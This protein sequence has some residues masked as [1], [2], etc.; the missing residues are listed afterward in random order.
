MSATTTTTVTVAM[1]GIGGTRNALAGIAVGD[2]TVEHV[3]QA[4]EDIAAGTGDTAGIARDA[5]RLL[6]EG[7]TYAALEW[8]PRVALGEL[9]VAAVVR[10][11]QLA[12]PVSELLHAV[13][14]AN[15]AAHRTRT[16]YYPGAE[17]PRG[18]EALPTEGWGSL[19]VA[20]WA[21]RGIAD[22]PACAALVDMQRLSALALRAASHENRYV[23]QV[24]FAILA[25]VCRRCCSQS[26]SSSLSALI[27]AN[28]HVAI[29]KA[30]SDSWAQVRFAAAQAA[31]AL[32]DMCPAE[33]SFLPAMLPA[34]FV[35][36]HDAAEGVR[37]QAQV[38]WRLAVNLSGKQL[39][40]AHVEPVTALLAEMCTSGSHELR[41]AA[42]TA[43]GELAAAVSQ[44]AVK[45]HAP[46]ILRVILVGLRDP[47]WAVKL[48]ACNAYHDFAG[49]FQAIAR[50]KESGA[51]DLLLRLGEDETACVREASAAALGAW[52]RAYGLDERALVARP[53]LLARTRHLLEMIRDEPIPEGSTK[54]SVCGDALRKAHFNDPAVHVSQTALG[55]CSLEPAHSDHGHA[56]A[57]PWQLVTGGAYLAR[58]VAAL[59]PDEEVAALVLPLL[60]EAYRA[61]WFVHYP[62]MHAAIS[63]QLP[64]ILESLGE[65]A[66]PH[67]HL[68]VISPP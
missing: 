4:R 41:S 8:K 58:E 6:G 16:E 38:N 5:V 28:A 37:L 12:R 40:A 68:S 66:A 44:R 57:A 22:Y 53:V 59:W 1:Q 35:S 20:M 64:R 9:V 24:A 26:S 17:G 33:R 23:R 31:R 11:P 2:A 30:L 13:V 19:E 27:R 39:L 67:R 65:R 52:A 25:A 15:I 60:D 62:N 50:A 10:D 42:C 46:Q 21:L 32:L 54:D 7:E 18:L 43:A 49:V 34:L 47:H 45:S 14:D 56:A 51:V 29:A 63:Q 3:A 48:A 55:C 61:R 36:R